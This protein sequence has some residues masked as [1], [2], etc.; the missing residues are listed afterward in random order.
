MQ[1]KSTPQVKTPAK[2]KS[3]NRK[4]LAN[5]SPKQN[6]ST[7]TPVAKKNTQNTFAVSPFAKAAG[8]DAHTPSPTTVKSVKTPQRNKSPKNIVGSTPEK[9]N[10]PTTG[11]NTGG[12]QKRKQ[13]LLPTADEGSSPKQQ[14]LAM[15]AGS[16][17]LN[18]STVKKTKTPVKSKKDQNEKPLNSTTPKTPPLRKEERIIRRKERRSA[19]REA[20]AALNEGRP[21]SPTFI[22]SVSHS[23]Q[24]L[25]SRGKLTKSGK[26]KL[27]T[28][29]K[30][31]KRFE[32]A[33][34]S[35]NSQQQVP[36]GKQ[37]PVTVKQGKK[38]AIQKKPVLNKS[39]P[40]P[41]PVLNKPKPKPVLNKPEDDAEGS[42]SDYDTEENVNVQTVAKGLNDDAE[43]QENGTDEDVSDEEM[44]DD[45]DE[46]EE[47][48][49]EEEGE[50]SE[51][52]IVGNR[53]QNAADGKANVTKS[54]YVLFV[55]NL[56]YEV[57]ENEIIEHFSKVGKVISVR[58]PFFITDQGKKLKGFAY[59]EFEDSQTYEVR[60]LVIS[61][62]GFKY[63]I[64]F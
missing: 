1:N 29:K 21:V 45:G 15:F 27:A 42:D 18:D 23:I 41:K 24:T 57:D 10:T 35:N 6:G 4:S 7:K 52:K 46:E 16:S 25:G 39:K 49:E 56:P 13:S 50:T 63:V 26:K 17:D 44:S 43:E 32:A 9:K 47:E 34:G 38:G 58:L 19:I 30:I 55:G 12:K 53:K 11:N 22:N 28:Y 64:S 2:R 62:S 3:L 40:K 20:F 8:D 37:K 54:R 51:E 33:T 60:F 5:A 59:V 31:Q 61:I 14:K 36:G 48:E